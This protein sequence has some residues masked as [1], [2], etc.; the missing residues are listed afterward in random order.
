MQIVNNFAWEL[1]SKPKTKTS[2]AK[3]SKTKSSKT[4]KAKYLFE[5]CCR[6][7]CVKRR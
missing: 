1:Y 3:S 5:V 2:K 6:F 7:D 4:V